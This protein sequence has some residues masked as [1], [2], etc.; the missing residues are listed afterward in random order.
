MGGIAIEGNACTRRAREPRV[1]DAE[2]SVSAVRCLVR[3]SIL[4]GS[5]DDTEEDAEGVPRRARSW[6]AK[7]SKLGFRSSRVR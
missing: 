4:I 3:E 6:V 7:I 2:R 1:V 5:D